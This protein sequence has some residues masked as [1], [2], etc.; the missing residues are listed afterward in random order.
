MH[1]KDCEASWTNETF[2][3]KS[4]KEK[5]SRKASGVSF[6][7][8][9]LRFFYSLL[10]LNA[11]FATKLFSCLIMFQ[12]CMLNHS[13]MCMYNNKASTAVITLSDTKQVEFWCCARNKKAMT[14]C[15]LTIQQGVKPDGATKIWTILNIRVRGDNTSPW[16]N[17]IKNAVEA[18]TEFSQS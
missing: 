15:K 14:Q 1:E 18:Y 12:Q 17:Q 8:Y 3:F 6:Q 13:V 4:F 11:H 2:Y 9:F 5:D 7:L 16:R 10:K